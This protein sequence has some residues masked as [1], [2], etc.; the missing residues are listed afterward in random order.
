MDKETIK[1][2]KTIAIISYIILFGPLIAMSINSENKNPFASFHIRQGLGLTIT[3]ITLGVTIS[4]FESIY[5]AMSLWI[6]I[7]VL[8]IY[9][10]VTA[11]NGEMRSM[12]LLG[13]LFHK[14]FKNL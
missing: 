7:T 4:H 8:A 9:G 6:F 5:I 11:A 12:P 3:F 14:L 1:K 13:T 2:G 10:I